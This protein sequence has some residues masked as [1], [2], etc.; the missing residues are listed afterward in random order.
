MRLLTERTN[1][2]NPSLWARSSWPTK[3]ETVRWL[4]ERIYRATE[5]G[6]RKE[7]QSHLKP[8]VKVP[9]A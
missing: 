3:Q 2:P 6:E 9:K 1:A 8:L 4:Q 7:V 5:G